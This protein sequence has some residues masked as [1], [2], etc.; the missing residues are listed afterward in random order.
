M[1]EVAFS[2]PIL[3]LRE[4]ESFATHRKLPYSEGEPNGLTDLGG[5]FRY[6]ASLNNYGELSLHNVAQANATIVAVNISF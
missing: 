4:S 1:R 2:R 3:P 6:S 5:M